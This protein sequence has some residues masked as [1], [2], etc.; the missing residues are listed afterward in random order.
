MDFLPASDIVRCEGLNKYTLIVTTQKTQLL[1]SYNI[2]EFA[3]TLQLYG[4]FSPH[5][6]HLINLRCIRRLTVENQI[7]LYD[8]SQVPLSRRR[9]L[10]FIQRFRANGA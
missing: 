10:E 2:G 8:G 6:S 3:K 5:K 4:F 9:R 7:I 1:S